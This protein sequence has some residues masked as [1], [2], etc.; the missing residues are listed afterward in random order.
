MMYKNMTRSFR[1]C[2]FAVIVINRIYRKRQETINPKFI[3]D[4][5]TIVNLINN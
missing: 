3:D 5:S 4:F 1:N 2:K